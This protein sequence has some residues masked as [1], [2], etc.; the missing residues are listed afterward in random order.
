[1][2]HLQLAINE[3]KSKMPRLELRLNEPMKNHCSF[4]IGG[5]VAAMALPGGREEAEELCR[6]LRRMGVRPFVMG[7]GT[8]LLVTDRPLNRIV[9]KM[10][11]KMGSITPHGDAGLTA[12]CGATLARLATAAQGL[13]L[14]GLEFA[15]GI[16][17]TL[18]GAVFMNAGAYGREMSQ[19][20][21]STVFLDEELR[22]CRF[23]GQE[24]G[25]SYRRS[26]FSDRDCVI[27]ACDLELKPGD[28]QE[29]RQC[30]RDLAK[31]RRSSQPLDMPS[32]G[33]VFKRPERGYAAA[34]I[35]QAGLKGYA[36]GGAQVSEK[37]AGFIVNR[38]GAS[39]DDVIRLMEHVRETVYKTAG[40]LLEPEVKIIA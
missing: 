27:L 20:V 23:S 31:R 16:P 17:G 24:H 33:S 7:N 8:N 13:G 15:H 18:G 35:D 6:L 4:R 10:S 25:F 9:I 11:E 32:A 34:L 36:V 38:G 14:S 5:P 21:R 39:F 1:M 40:I 29:I 19:V 37:H 26:A 28:P 3:I 12:G 22:V 30:M 2:E